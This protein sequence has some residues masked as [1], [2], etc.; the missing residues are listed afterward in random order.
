MTYRKVLFC[1]IFL[2]VFLISPVV[3]LAQV[4]WVKD[5][6]AALRQAE[7]GKK[8]IVLDLSASW[9]PH[10]RRMT[11]EVYS[12]QKFIEFSRRQVFVRVFTDT[13][14]Q[15]DRLVNKF[16]V[17]GYPTIIILDSSGDEVDRIMGFRSAPDLIEELES[18]F[19]QAGGK[20][21]KIWT[22]SLDADSGA[23]S[24]RLDLS[25]EDP[26][27]AGERL[28]KKRSGQCAASPA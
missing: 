28:S 12:D 8:F 15:G 24:Y 9:W 20:G 5:F 13:D 27:I 11:R 22:T 1:G 25:R 6:N 7:R 3:S 26:E 23:W 18:I 16:N 10:C 4:A 2:A 17:D 21:Y 14:S 19:E